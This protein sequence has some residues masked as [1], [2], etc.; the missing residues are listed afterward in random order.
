MINPKCFLTITIKEYSAIMETLTTFK[1]LGVQ[2]QEPILK[3]RS[4]TVNLN[5]LNSKFYLI[6]SYCE[7]FFY[8]FP[9]ISCLKCTVNSNFHLIRSKILPTNDFELTVPNLYKL[10]STKAYPPTRETPGSIGYD[11]RSPRFA[12]IPPRGGTYYIP[13]GIAFQIPEGHYGR[14]APRSGL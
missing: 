13:M 6:R 8:H 9:N 10:L 3:Y 7:I 4:G 5:M 12:R 14:L 11:L 1:P 2:G